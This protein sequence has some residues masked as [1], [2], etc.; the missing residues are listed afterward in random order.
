MHRSL[1]VACAL[2]PIASR[3]SA[4]PP[5]PPPALPAIE[6]TANHVEIDHAPAIPTDS[7]FEVGDAAIKPAARPLLDAIGKALAKDASSTFSINCYT[8]DTAPDND[9]TGAYNQKLSLARADAVLAYLAK[10]GVA[11]KRM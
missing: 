10:H 1:L 8:D 11:A 7:L 4:D 3:A 9:R 5:S 6:I 2:W